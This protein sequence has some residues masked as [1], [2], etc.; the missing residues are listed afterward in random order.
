MIYL[1]RPV[2]PFYIYLRET[3]KKTLNIQGG[4]HQTQKYIQKRKRVG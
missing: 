4:P 2:I 3:H 1:F